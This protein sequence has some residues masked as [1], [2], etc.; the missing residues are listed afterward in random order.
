MFCHHYPTDDRLPQLYA[1]ENVFNRVLVV[2]TYEHDIR[3]CGQWISSTHGLPCI[4]T[5]DLS[6]LG[7]ADT[8]FILEPALFKGI[9]VFI[10]ERSDENSTIHLLGK[11]K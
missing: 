1:G 4:R 9:N 2:V 8:F 10:A 3:R 7:R 5:R 11:I 6:V